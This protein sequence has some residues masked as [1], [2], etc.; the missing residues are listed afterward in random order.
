MIDVDGTNVDGT[1]VD[2]GHAIGAWIEIHGERPEW[3]KDNDKV[4]IKWKYSGIV[5]NKPDTYAEHVCGWEDSVSYIALAADHPHY[6]AMQS[7]AMQSESEQPTAIQTDGDYVRVKRMTIDEMDV[8]LRDVEY[9]THALFV[10]LGI[11]DLPETLADKFHR[12]TGFSI[13]P[14]VAAALEYGA[15]HAYKD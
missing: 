14:E 8:M 3:L 15:N 6:A 11:I 1:N 4:A 13:T 12:E 5:W 7:D 10:Q 2:G 9:D